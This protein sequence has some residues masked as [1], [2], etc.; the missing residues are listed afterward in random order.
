[1]RDIPGYEGRFAVTEDGRV[2][3]HPKPATGAFKGRGTLPGKWL[4]GCNSRGYRCVGIGHKNLQAIHRLVALTY[5]P[6][7]LGK[8]HVNHKNGNKADN[9]VENLEW[10]TQKEN[11]QHAWRTGLARPPRKIAQT[12]IPEIHSLHASG[13]THSEIGARFGVGRGTVQRVLYGTHGYGINRGE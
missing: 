1:M 7:V 9:R 6:R 12:D 13:L 2:W 10:C 11:N 5:L 3:S 4:T 8:N